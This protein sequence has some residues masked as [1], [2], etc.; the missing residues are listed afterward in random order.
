MPRTALTD[1]AIRRI[2]QPESGTVTYWDTTVKGL[3]VRVS[4]TARTFIVLIDSGRRQKIGRYPTLTLADARTEAKRTLAEKTLGRVRPVHTAFD[5]AKTTFLNECEKTN[6]PRTVAEYRRLLTRHF[7]FGRRSVGDITARDITKRLARLNETPAE[8]HHAFTAGR[9]FFN[10]C[11]ARHLIETSPMTA[12][13][14]AAPNAPRDRV[15]TKE[16]LQRVLKTALQGETTFHRIVALLALTGQ[17][18]SEIAHLE[19]AWIGADRITLP[20]ALTKNK[21]EHMFPIG[22]V[23]ND[24]IARTPRLKD[25]PYV[26]PA[27]RDAKKDKPTTVFNGWGKPKAR[28]DKGCGVTG[29]TL[30]DLRRTLATNWAALGISQTVTE[31]YINHISGGSQSPI[32]QVY[33]RHAY[34]DEQRDAV[35]RWEAYLSVL[36]AS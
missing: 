18:R 6:R 21:R 36:L 15:L 13:S 32:A 3:G 17:R 5:D 30:H 16:E 11:I 12:L 4:K 20:A 34:R 7:P 2:P 10:W 35:E 8:R 1:L 19:W 28:F 26:F 9:R 31:K 22:K 27:Q 33:N 29:W 24:V 23:A 14:Y 25:N